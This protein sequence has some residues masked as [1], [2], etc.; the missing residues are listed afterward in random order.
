MGRRGEVGG[1]CLDQSLRRRYFGCGE[2]NGLTGVERNRPCEGIGDTEVEEALRPA[3]APGPAVENRPRPGPRL[4]QDRVHLGERVAA[5]DDERLV[6]LFRQR[7][8]VSK[9]PDL[10]LAGRQV[11]V[12]VE[13]GLTD[14]AHRPGQGC[15]LVSLRIP[16]LGVVGMEAGRGQDSGGESVRQGNR[17]HRAAG[18]DSRN[19]HPVDLGSSTEQDVGAPFVELQMAVAVDPSHRRDSRRDRQITGSSRGAVTRPSVR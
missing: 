3:R 16:V 14:R 4:L 2:T 1:V 10:V 18:V 13:T 9:C 7:N 11:P 8:V 6:V 17:R 15:D 12:E 19:H 5:V